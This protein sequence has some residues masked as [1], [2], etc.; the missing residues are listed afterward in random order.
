MKK[1]F[2]TQTKKIQEQEYNFVK[3]R[4]G[5]KSKMLESRKARAETRARARAR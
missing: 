1:N 2:M 4:R 5:E 3:S